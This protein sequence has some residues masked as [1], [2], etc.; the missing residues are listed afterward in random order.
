VSEHIR[1]GNHRALQRARRTS[2]RI[3]ETKRQRFLDTLAATCN[4]CMAAEAAGAAASSFYRLRRRDTAFADAWQEAI[5]TGYHRLEEALLD[6]A[7]SRVEAHAIDPDAADPATVG[8]SEVG[9]LARRTVSATDLQF[10]LALLGR[11]RAMAEGRA[12]LIR[13]AHRATAEET[14]AALRKHLDVLARQL[15]KHGA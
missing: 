12:R 4:V 7:L 5:T 11:H 14:D 3:T 6:Y 8:R 13:S 1:A 15:K 9:K 2:H 10:A